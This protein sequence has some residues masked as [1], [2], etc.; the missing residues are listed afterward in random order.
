MCKALSAIAWGV[1]DVT[2]SG[3]LGLLGVGKALRRKIVSFGKEQTLSSINLNLFLKVV[4]RQMS[5]QVNRMVLKYPESKLGK[6]GNK[7]YWFR[8]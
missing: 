1:K 8:S 5:L 3:V 2:P 4:V 7:Q 6:Y